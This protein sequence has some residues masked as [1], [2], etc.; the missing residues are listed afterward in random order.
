MQLQPLAQNIGLTDADAP[1]G[2]T[3]RPRIEFDNS[4][5][6]DLGVK[7]YRVSYRKGTSG[8]FI[9]LTAPI[10]R[11][12][13]HEVGDDL[14]LEEFNL[15]PK[16]EKSPGVPLLNPN[17]FEIPPALPPIGQWSIPDAVEDTD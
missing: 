13:T 17:L 8:N 12:Y 9:P 1:F 14:V 3:L 5:R 15:G 2:E 6:E 4:L 16:S 10:S 11:H 7:Y